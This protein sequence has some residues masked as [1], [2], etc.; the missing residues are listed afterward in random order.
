MTNT[1]FR[2]FD[3][4]KVKGE[5]GFLEGLKGIVVDY[6]FGTNNEIWYKVKFKS[7]HD[8]NEVYVSSIKGS[9][10]ELVERQGKAEWKVRCTMIGRFY[11]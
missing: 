5:S 1:N 4:V 9:Q 8:V 2:L 7:V 3:N 11:Y 6:N 10:L